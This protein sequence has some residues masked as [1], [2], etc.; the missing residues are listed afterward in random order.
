MIASRISRARNFAFFALPLFVLAVFSV[1]LLQASDHSDAPVGP[2]GARVDANISDLHA[3]VNGSNL[4]LAL[5]TNTGIPTSAASYVFPTDVTFEFNIDND[6]LVDPADPNGDG[7][8]IMKPEKISEEIVFRVRFR[9]D[10]SAKIQRIEMGRDKGDPQIVNFFAGLRDDPFIRG[11][12]QGRNVGS[13]V[14]EVPLAS[15]LRGSNTMLVIWATAQV[16][17]FDGPFQEIVG[18]SL[19][20]MFPE[21][22]LLNTM[23][24]RQQFRLTGKRPDVMMYN[25]ALPAAFP[26]GRA[27]TDD[28]V[29]LVG[30]NRVLANDAPFPSTNDLPFLSGFPYLAAPHPPR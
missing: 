3:F 4:V 30:D 2:A 8:T 7:G 14:L 13:I 11:P 25:V 29:N 6:C 17:E 16:E 15:V 5:S 10:G 19:K 9:D 20:S 21:N 27:L 12:R 28:V 26:N 24:P 22:A 18:R 23:H 1:T